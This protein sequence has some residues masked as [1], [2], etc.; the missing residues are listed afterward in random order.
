MSGR[1]R[2]RFGVYI[3]IVKK[4]ILGVDSG[5]LLCYY[6]DGTGDRLIEHDT[7]GTG[8]YVYD[9]CYYTVTLLVK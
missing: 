8:E 5:N 2:G 6:N 7:S 9:N 1:R 3:T 4:I